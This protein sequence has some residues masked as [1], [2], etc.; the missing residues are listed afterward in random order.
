MDGYILLVIYIQERETQMYRVIE[1][2]PEFV[3]SSEPLQESLIDSPAAAL[4]LPWLKQ[5][6]ADK[7]DY[8]GTVLYV[9]TNGRVIAII[10]PEGAK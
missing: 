2:R 7:V 6:G 5:K 10:Y 3:D 8:V 1:Y 9:L 4:E